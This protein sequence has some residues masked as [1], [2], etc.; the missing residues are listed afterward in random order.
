M[1]GP[2]KKPK[3]ASMTKNNEQGEEGP[4]IRLSGWQAQA[5][6]AQSAPQESGFY[7]ECH[8]KPLEEFRQES[9]RIFFPF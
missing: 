1:L 3:I 6:R 8:R 7:S 9:D 2:L 5:G 4:E